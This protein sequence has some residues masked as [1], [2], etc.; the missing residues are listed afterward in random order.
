M[1]E[2]TVQC[3]GLSGC[4]V[5]VLILPVDDP[6]PAVYVCPSCGGRAR[7]RLLRALDEG[8]PLAS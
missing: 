8:G 5:G 4:P 2:H 7:Q 3:E 6:V 1:L